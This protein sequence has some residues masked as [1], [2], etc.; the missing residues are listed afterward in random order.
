MFNIND[1]IPTEKNS[2]YKRHID[3]L[4]S[5]GMNTDSIENAVTNAIEN[6]INKNTR[7]FVIYGEPQSGKTE[8]MIALTAKLLDIGNKIVIILLNDNVQLLNQNLNRFRRSDI[9]PSPKNFNEILDPSIHIANNEWV[10]FCKKNSK[11]LQNLIGKLEKVSKKIIIDDEA[12]YATPNSKINRGEKT[13][14]NE[15][16]ERLLSFDGIYIGVTATPARLDLNNTFE[17]K[18]DKWIDFVPH[19]YYTGQDIFFPTNILTANSIKFNLDLLPDQGDNPSH[20][21][22]ALFKFFIN[23]AFLNITGI[24][25]NYCMLIHTSGKKSDHT[26]DYNQVVKIFDILK[27][28]ESKHYANYV[29]QIWTIAQELHPNFED[30]ITKYILI[31]ILKNVIVVMNSDTDKNIVDYESATNPVALFTIAIGGNIVSRG[32]TFNNLLSMFFTR[33]VKHKIQQDTYIQRARMFGSRQDYL[34]HFS[35]HI[36]KDLYEDWRRCF[37]FH[38]LSLSAIKTGKG[39]PVWLEDS[40]VSAVARNSIDATTVDMNSG[41]IDFTIFK[42][43]EM[44]CSIIHD[45]SKTNLER[46]I[47]LSEK[48]GD[49][50]LPS[51]ILDF[52][53]AQLPNGDLSI[54]LHG[55]RTAQNNYANTLERPRGTFGGND[56]KKFPDAIHHLLI[57]RNNQGLARIIYAYNGRIRIVRNRGKK[58]DKGI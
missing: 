2:R 34:N 4:I 53:K 26:E 15:L 20:L 24:K 36:P 50:S 56:F 16:I 39:A 42:F 12:D 6:I 47:I 43:N 21:R 40:R 46:L 3:S 38:R 35:L 13:R 31:N 45:K 7:S 57:Y 58:D 1:F 9:D 19:P 14:I 23:T 17:N 8:M 51:Y 52:I 5:L 22:K 48:I 32:M 37:V 49:V 28:Q 27:D 33:D 29:E 55:I 10:I 11:D 41:E 30:K 25:R 44:D 18:N 54:G